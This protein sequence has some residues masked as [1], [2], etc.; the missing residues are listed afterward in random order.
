MTSLRSMCA[1]FALAALTTTS[2]NG[3][4]APTLAGPQQGSVVVVHHAAVKPATKEP[5]FKVA[6]T[7]NSC[8]FFG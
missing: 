8:R 1:V 5:E 4:A 6:P 3:F 7:C 2:T